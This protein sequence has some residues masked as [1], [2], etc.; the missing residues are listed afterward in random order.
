[1][2]IERLPEAR[3][4][5][6]QQSVFDTGLY[7]DL[8][9]QV[10]NLRRRPAEGFGAATRTGRYDLMNE[11]SLPISWI[12][13]YLQLRPF[14]QTRL[15]DYERVNDPLAGSEDRLSLGGGISASQQWSR[16]FDVSEGVLNDWFRIDR[17]KHAVVPKVT[18][19]N[20]FVNDLPAAETLGFDEVDTV[21]LEETIALSLRQT[22]MS[23]RTR[24]PSPAR[25]RGLLDETPDLFQ[26]LEY[27]TRSLLDS[28]VSLI[29]FPREERDNNGDA[30]SLVTFDNTIRP[31]RHTHLRAWFSSDISRDAFRIDKTDIALWAE[32]V[33]DVFSL[34]IGDRFSR[35][36]NGGTDRHFI[37][38]LSELTLSPRWKVQSY[39]SHDLES[40]ETNEVSVGL[41]R[42]MHRFALFLEYSFDQGEDNNHT[43]SVNFSPLSM[44]RGLRGRRF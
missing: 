44:F 32:L 43:V 8:T 12:D 3:F 9:A 26:E 33:P 38:T 4:F 28:E 19:F 17:L 42:V 14:F 18:Y 2:E 41:I 25:Q 24:V 7:T 27:E 22:L 23:R 35:G 5:L 16:V 34:T 36:R 31:G 13:P 37:Y 21:D 20:R 29:L 30:T 11:W 1:T 10:A 6:F 15:T 40:G 39:W